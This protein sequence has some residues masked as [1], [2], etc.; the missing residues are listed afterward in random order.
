MIAS[1]HAALA[2]LRPAQRNP[3]IALVVSDEAGTYRPEMQWLAAQLQLQGK[4]VF[5]LRPEDLFPLENAL[6]FDVEGNPEKID[7]IYRFLELFG[8]ESIRTQKFIFESWA[9]ARCRSRR[10]CGIFRRRKSARPVSPPPGGFLGGTLSSRALK[11]LRTLIP[12]S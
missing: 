10:R 2:A 6:F 7:V 11:L 9:A 4:R 8:L 12:L 5:C 3:L 1:F